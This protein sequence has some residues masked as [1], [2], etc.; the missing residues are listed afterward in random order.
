MPPT[1]SE[2]FNATCCI[3]TGRCRPLFAGTTSCLFTLL[4]SLTDSWDPSGGSWITSGMSALARTASES[5]ANIVM[6][7]ATYDNAKY[8]FLAWAIDAVVTAPLASK[9][10]SAN[11]ASSAAGTSYAAL[12]AGGCGGANAQSPPQSSSVLPTAS[13]PATGATTSGMVGNGGLV[14][15]VPASLTPHSPIQSLLPSQRRRPVPTVCSVT[16]VDFVRE[17][18]AAGSQGQLG[19]VTT[20]GAP[21]GEDPS[22]PN[23]ASPRSLKYLHLKDLT[24]ERPDRMPGRFSVMMSNSSGMVAASTAPVDDDSAP[25]SPHHRRRD[26]PQARPS[27]AASCDSVHPKTIPMSFIYELLADRS[28]NANQ[29][30]SQPQP[31]NVNMNHSTLIMGGIGAA[32]SEWMYELEARDKAATLPNHVTDIATSY[33]Q[34][35]AYRAAMVTTTTL[36]PPPVL[37]VELLRPQLL[38]QD[39]AAVKRASDRLS[40]LLLKD[41]L[42]PS[43]ESHH[44][45]QVVELTTNVVAKALSSSESARKPSPVHSDSHGGYCARLV[46][47]FWLL[48]RMRDASI[49]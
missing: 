19:A 5:G 24:W 49:P 31:T 35:F 1:L 47:V 44:N 13:T 38:V 40:T 28:S 18:A 9:S 42:A 32:D 20:T 37:S 43:G 25:A 11:A 6:D 27:A 12:S 17:V 41:D 48:S 30:H 3:G 7:A 36:S 8:D 46:S 21:R 10:P 22:G 16:S 34:A 15:L 14:S 2:L 45:Q 23:V 39:T 4:P 26:Q 33:F 29:Q